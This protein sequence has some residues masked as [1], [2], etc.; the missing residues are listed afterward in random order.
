ME[1]HCWKWISRALSETIS[2]LIIIFDWLR[3][4]EQMASWERW[5][6]SR[7]RRFILNVRLAVTMMH[8]SLTS[9]LSSNRSLEESVCTS[10]DVC[11]AQEPQLWLCVV[12]SPDSWGWWCPWIS[13]C[14]CGMC[15]IGA[16]KTLIIIKA[17]YFPTH[18]SLPC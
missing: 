10:V 12:I 5:F 8:C 11:E 14:V 7:V 4:K 3:Q 15:K 18:S 16:K 1:N 6:R 17:P 2:P 13:E 9:L